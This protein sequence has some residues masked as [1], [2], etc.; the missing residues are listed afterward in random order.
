MLKNK[1][2][3]NSEIGSEGT[4]YSRGKC[5]GLNILPTPLDQTPKPTVR[6]RENPGGAISLKRVNNL[7]Q[8]PSLS[9]MSKIEKGII[10]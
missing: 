6:L 2:I 1:R 9:S 7:P 5:N 10:P 4:F 3:K 8:N